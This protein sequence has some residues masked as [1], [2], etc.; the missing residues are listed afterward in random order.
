MRLVARLLPKAQRKKMENT[1]AIATLERVD[2]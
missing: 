2:G 1:L